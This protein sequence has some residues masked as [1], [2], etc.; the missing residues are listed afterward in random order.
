MGHPKECDIDADVESH[1]KKTCAALQGLRVALKRGG[2]PQ[3]FGV[4]LHPHMP[5]Y[6]DKQ[7]PSWIA[8]SKDK[9]C[10][11]L[12]CLRTTLAPLFVQEDDRRFNSSLLTI[13]LFEAG[14]AIV[15]AVQ[16]RHVASDFQAAAV[17]TS[18]PVPSTLSYLFPLAGYIFSTTLLCQAR[19][20]DG[21]K[22]MPFWA[23]LGI[24]FGVVLGLAQQTDAVQFCLAYGPPWILFGLG[25]G[26]FVHAHGHLLQRASLY[27][28][29]SGA[30][31]QG[32]EELMVLS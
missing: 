11:E 24:G 22:L 10:D 20:R 29:K 23:L 7:N 14:A 19:W 25:L 12:P 15:S 1:M 27:G 8:V 4:V 16:L 18:A 17:S 5:L 9:Y 32:D 26:W 3:L 2:W 28:L 31:F 30:A 6:K 21:D 13:S